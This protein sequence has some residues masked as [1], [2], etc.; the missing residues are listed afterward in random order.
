MPRLTIDVSEAQSF[1]PVEDDL[2][3]CEITAISEVKQG[4][5]ARYLTA[6][7]TIEHGMQTEEAFAGR[8]L[9]TNLPIEGAGAGI[10]TSFWER[11]TG[12]ELD[13]EDDELDIDTDDLVGEKI[14]VQTKQEEYPPNSGEF[15]SQ[16]KKVLSASAA[17]G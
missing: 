3:L 17:E 5:K 12:E 8:K 16:V 4:Q 6:E 10:F 14:A 2:Y 13:L 11:A 9:F 7:M 1:D 15:R